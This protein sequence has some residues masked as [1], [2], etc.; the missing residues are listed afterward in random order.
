M[1]YSNH[2]LHLTVTP[3]RSIPAA[4]RTARHKIRR[5]ILK[6]IA[7][8]FVVVMTAVSATAGNLMTYFKFISNGV[9][10]S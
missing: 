2:A 8:I 5:L 4:E 10:T 3:L 6:R 9:G 1:N 7:L